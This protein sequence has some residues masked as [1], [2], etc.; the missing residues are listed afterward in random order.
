LKEGQVPRN[1]YDYEKQRKVNMKIAGSRTLQFSFRD[2]GCCR[3]V[4]FL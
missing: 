3:V 1:L 2:P 4:L